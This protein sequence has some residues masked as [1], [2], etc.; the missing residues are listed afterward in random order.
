MAADKPGGYYYELVSTSGQE[1]YTCWICHNLLREP[2]LTNCCGQHYCQTCLQKWLEQRGHKTCP[3][4]RKEFTYMVN[5]ERKRDVLDLEV[6]C[7]YHTLGCSFTTKLQNMD[8]H[9]VSC[10]NAETRCKLNCMEKIKH[11]EH[12]KHVKYDCLNREYKCELCQHKS[13]YTEITGETVM[14]SHNPDASV[15]PIPPEK[16]HYGKCPEYPKTCPNECGT[17]TKRKCMQEHRAN[18]PKERVQCSLRAVHRLKVVHGLR[19]HHFRPLHSMERCN[20][21]MERQLLT[22][23]QQHECLYRRYTCQFCNMEDT[24]TEITG[25][26]A[27][28]KY[29]PSSVPNPEHDVM[30]NTPPERGHYAWCLHYP[31]AC[32]NECG[33]TIKRVSMGEHRT[34]CPK[35]RVACGYW[36]WSANSWWP[37]KCSEVMERQSLANHRQYECLY[38]WY[39]CQFCGMR[40]TY[41]T[42][43]GQTE[44]KKYDP[45]SVPDPEHDAM[46]NPPPEKGHYAQCPDYPKICPNVCGTTIKRKY[47]REHRATCPKERVRCLLPMNQTECR[48][49]KVMER[50]LLANHRQYECLHRKYTCQ[51]CNLESI[52]MQIT[53]ETE[54]K[55]YNPSSFPNPVTINPPPERGHYAQCPDYPKTCPNKCGMTIKRKCMQKHSEVCPKERVQCSRS[56]G[57]YF[58]CNEVME[59]HLLANHQQYE[60]LRREYTC[61]FCNK[62]DTYTQI[63]GE[64]E[65]KKYDPSSAPNPEYNA[66]IN[67]PPERGHYARCRHYP[68]TCPNECGMTIERKCMQE[69][70]KVCPKE[71]VR[72]SLTAERPTNYMYM[73]CRCNEV[74]ERQLLA[75]HCQHECLYREYTCQF[76]SLESTYEKITGETVMKKFNPSSG[77]PEHDATLNPPPERG[78]YALCEKYPLH[79][80]NK[81]KEDAILR[82]DMPS[83]RKQCP[84]EPVEC[85][86]REGGCQVK[87]VRKELDRHVKNSTTEHLEHLAGI[88][89]EFMDTKK[90]LMETKEE[91]ME[92]KEELMETKKELEAT[93]RTRKNMYQ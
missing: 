60:C 91:L 14:T 6:K 26:R 74:M 66:I 41:T 30:I 71:T 52:Y 7:T 81:C 24:Y 90:E 85:P 46:I 88:L 25:E 79:C 59:R 58:G 68:K 75:N 4:C 61:Q 87:P 49:N 62:E 22:N 76:C 28:K 37:G 53:G 86:F 11:V 47:M 93:K 27:M 35:E 38:R 67:P 56:S 51:F 18:C 5:Q 65:M 69:H 54:V 40:S 17:T 80:P 92:T 63:T 29:D 89:Q 3:Q 78:H 72:C 33:M 43:T 20:E 57:F 44:T 42:V 45:S 73:G 77:Y 9:V 39:T 8:E 1:R 32:P 70:R 15:R 13:T 31:K 84:M 55:K 2:T 83:H 64:T 12:E 10:S 19:V 50:Q 36:G 23:H 16:G 82:E 34:T 48:C 21:E